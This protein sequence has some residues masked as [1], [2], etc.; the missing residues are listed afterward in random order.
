MAGALDGLLVIDFGQYVAGPLLAQI[1]ADHGAEVIRIDPPGGPRWTS[2]SNA[3]LQRGKQSVVLDLQTEADRAL[4]QQLVQRADVVVENF[5]PGVMDRLGLGP[6]E[7]IAQ[8]D[9]LVYCSLPGFAS[10]DPRA[11]VAAHEMVVSA[12]A[13][14]YPPRNF[15]PEGEPV[16]NTLPLASVFAAMIGA[17]SVVAAL[18][19][20]ETTGTG[21]RVEVSLYDAA[22]E[23]TRFYG[24][25][26]TA[27]PRYPSYFMLGG[28]Y[29]PPTADHYQCADDRWVHLSW[30][31]GRQFED[32][33]R[34]VGTYDEWNA[35]GLF[36]IPTARFWADLS[37]KP[38]VRKLL[39]PI[40]L[41]RTASEWESLLNP[42]CDLTECCTTQEWLLYDQQARALD[43]AVTVADPVLGA[44]H[45]VGHAVTM[46]AT[47]PR[48]A[49]P[50]QQLDEGRERALEIV[51]Q[52][53][54]PRAALHARPLEGALDGVTVLDTCQLLAG[55]TAG[56]I[57]AEYGADVI[58][59]SH[60]GGRASLEYHR[61]TNA[62]KSTISLDLKAPGGL[63]TFWTLV[64]RADVL[65]TNFSDSVAKRLGVD[66]S[67][68]RQHRPD[69]VY[70]RLSAHGPRG[71]RADY[72][73]HEQVGQTVT[74]MQIRYGQGHEHPV[75]QPFAIN[76][77]G[78][79]H[80]TALGVLLALFHRKRT[81]QGQWVGSSL[82]QVAALYQTP[83]MIEHRRRVWNDP[84]G[85]DFRGANATQ[86]VYRG[87][88]GWFALASTH[89]EEGLSAL[90]RV[91]G[92]DDLDISSDDLVAELSERFGSQPRS[93][94]VKRLLEEGIGAHECCSITEA[95]DDP[96]A[97][98][99]GLSR[100][101]TFL[102]GDDGRVVGPPP[103]L[104]ATPMRPGK[105]ASPLGS[106]TERILHAS[107]VPARATER[108]GS[109]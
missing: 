1:M 88:D 35:R 46:D 103:R 19:A 57:L 81:G 22:F 102:E 100:D 63:D 85:I 58:H 52:P 47:P 83:Y 77:V 93:V 50:R 69:I 98:A 105:P 30:L 5:R 56:R 39:E 74:G 90:S 78:A 21:Q 9:Q 64:D 18:I 10:D 26:T 6:E 62:G 43:T 25:R 3:I 60:P 33:A 91:E 109:L 42:E 28:S 61:T 29:D 97:R 66:E 89:F 23:I 40:F 27:V 94:W 67:S 51:G 44:T 79:G 36:G 73:G 107:G 37:L 65:S 70:S 95:M 4:A 20:R 108:A 53:S 99:H 68:V 2:D 24:D 48:V 31:E 72:R 49:S 11:A 7:A 86:H 75:M 16:V 71:P 87:N 15:E 59:I 106:D 55:P 32:F 8:N 54:A 76:D 96:W 82:T 41:T 13:G 34:Y 80:A 101:V 92:L 14:L 38:V 84:G 12:A 45:Q 17:N 104:T